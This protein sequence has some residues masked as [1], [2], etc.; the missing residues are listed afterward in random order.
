MN[1]RKGNTQLNAKEFQMAPMIDVMFLLLIFFMAIAFYAKW[2]TQIGINLPKSETG[3]QEDKLPGEIIIN[4]TENGEIF[5]NRSRMNFSRLRDILN[6]IAVNYSNQ[7]IVVR[8]D[9]ETEHRFVVKVLDLC[10]ELNL[11]HVAIAAI[12]EQAGAQNNQE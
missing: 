3:T 7:P 5:I 9:G 10:K 4:I 2:E 1:F 12:P 6:S 11:S 8:A